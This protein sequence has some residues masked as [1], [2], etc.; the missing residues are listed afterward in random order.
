MS[1]GQA[2][3]LAGGKKK[4][5]KALSIHDHPARCFI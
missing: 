3:F 1:F 5:E 2:V 4:D